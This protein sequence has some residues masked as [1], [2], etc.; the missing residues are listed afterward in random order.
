LSIAKTDIE[1]GAYLSYL[2]YSD[3][4]AIISQLG[5]SNWMPQDYNGTII[6]TTLG[7]GEAFAVKSDDTLVIAFRGTKGIAD[8][9]T[10]LVGGI[11]TFMGAALAFTDFV[12][13]FVNPAILDPAIKKIIFTGHSLGGVMAEIW[14]NI[15][16]DNNEVVGV[17]F[18]SPGDRS[19]SG[20]SSNLLNIGHTNDWVNNAATSFLHVFSSLGDVGQETQVLLP[21]TYA[22][23]DPFGTTFLGLFD[24]M[25]GEHQKNLYWRTAYY[26]THSFYSDEYIKN[27]NA[28]AVILGDAPMTVD[29]TPTG[30]PNF[31]V[32]GSGP[33]NDLA[34]NDNLNAF[35]TF[36]ESS[37]RMWMIGG[38]GSDTI[39]GGIGDDLIEGDGGEDTLYGGGGNDFISGGDG[40]DKLLVL[41]A[42]TTVSDGGSGIDELTLYRPDLTA[43]QNVNFVPGGGFSLTDGTS[44]SN[45]ELLDI[46]LG[47][48]NDTVSLTE[49]VAGENSI[50]AGGGN[51][52]VTVDFSAFSSDVVSGLYSVYN[53]YRYFIGTQPIGY[54]NNYNAPIYADITYLY[55]VENYIFVGG[56][57]NDSLIGQGGNDVLIGND[58]N[59][60]LYGQDG[61]DRLYGGAGDDSLRVDTGNS[62]LS[63]G[64]GDDKLL[65]LGAGTTV[66]D[67]GSGIDKLTL[68]RPDLTANQNVNFV[69]GGGFSLTDGTSVSNV[70]LLDITLGS[71]N[72]TVSLTEVVAGENS[73]NAGGGNDT[74][75]V[76]FS[77]FSSDVVS[78]LY[79]V[80]NAY[81]YFIGTQPIGYNNNYNTPIYA[82]ITYLYNVENYI[83]VG[84]SGNDSLIGQG[85]NDV[86]IGL[87]GADSLFG[88]A[89]D[90][91][92]YFDA[93]DLAANVNGG[94]DTD[95]LVVVDGDLPIGFNLVGSGFEGAEWNRTDT[96]GQPWSFIQSFHDANWNTYS[97]TTYYDNGTRSATVNN[98]TG[99]GDWQTVRYDYN[100][101]SALTL[102]VQTFTDQT[103]IYE[104]YD[105]A[106]T[107]VWSSLRTDYNAALQW[108]QQVLALDS[109]TT[110]YEQFDP[111]D[112]QVWSSLRT[113]YSATSEWLQQVVVFDDGLR[114]YDLFDPADLEAWS[115]YRNVYTSTLQ[116]QESKLVDDSGTYTTVDYDVANTQTWNE[117]H[118]SYSATNVLLNEYF[119]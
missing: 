116:L 113:D 5:G 105:L 7:G 69:P 70:E 65:V 25:Q 107:Q 56:S 106:D 72:D 48:G 1:D 71:G 73:I 76:D 108:T 84:G 118:R 62:L 9:A 98:L 102:Q 109:G 60:N 23:S 100:A 94:A 66:S 35:T 81:R 11:A 80:Y 20:Y 52:T 67:G 38:L 53:A 111:A 83:F 57:G 14:Q 18:A 75:T 26:L 103:R 42:G 19:I 47:S 29:G 39:T 97:V 112:T 58:G 95:T 63:G 61:N 99:V 17:T 49:V 87:G 8:L 37:T 6:Q 77:A 114:V 104:E 43:N 41:G 22:S 31:I 86:L 44:V 45:V 79:S 68:Y 3:D 28:F 101:A 46:T 24:P 55:N 27:P 82:D 85:G 92:I 36:P 78:G 21:N 10:D 33:S 64:D 91:R 2:A 90:D 96:T 15:Y 59:D 54:N 40:D 115:S 34:V 30:T 88:G 89:G 12:H 117:W 119:V 50:N 93:A 51:D 110:V 16:T 32:N 74:V 4:A 13:H